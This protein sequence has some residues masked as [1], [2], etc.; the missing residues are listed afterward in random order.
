MEKARVMNAFQL[1]FLGGLGVLAAI[2]FGAAIGQLATILT[3]V[4]LALFISLGMDPMV[5]MMIKAKLPRPIAVIIV[6]FAFLSV[7]AVLLWAI[8]P[9]AVSEAGKLIGRVPTIIENIVDNRLIASYDAQL[10]GAISTAAENAIAFVSDSGNW[11]TLLGGVFQIGAG[12]LSGVVGFVIVVILSIYFMVSL[13]SLKDYLGLLVAKSKRESFRKLSDQISISVGRWVMGQTS[14][15]LLHSILLFVLLTLLGS[16][17]ALLLSMAAF[18]LALIPLIGPASAG[19]LVVGVTYLSGAS[20]SLVVLIYYLVYLQ[21]EAYLIGPRVM[22]KAVAIPAA[23]VVIAALV[24][25]TLLGVLGALVAIPV[26][27]AILLVVREVWIPRQQERWKVVGSGAD[28]GKTVCAIASRTRLV[29]L[30]PTHKCFSPSNSNNLT[31]GT[32]A[33][34]GRASAGGRNSSSSGTKATNLAST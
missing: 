31:L 13:E 30:S 15:A 24:G 34:L 32:M 7:V 14:I 22:Q 17:F 29:A 2:F 1:G 10:G 21:I 33:N 16:P 3:Y 28:P 23:V 19:L 11:P 25:G 27:A 9:M 5:R 26:A 12:V 6:I 4:G 8:L 20:F 18:L